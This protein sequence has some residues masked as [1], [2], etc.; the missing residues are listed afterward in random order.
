MILLLSCYELGHQPL[1]IAWP[2]AFLERAG[3]APDTLDLAF[4]PWDDA[5]IRR[6]KLIAIAVPMHTALRLGVRTAQRIRRANPDCRI[7][8]HGLYARSTRSTCSRAS[9]TMS[10]VANSKSRSSIW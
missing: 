1:G 4:E 2:K 9:L 10:L 3:F 8:F 5:K 6:A 7:V